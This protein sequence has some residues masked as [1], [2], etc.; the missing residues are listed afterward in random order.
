MY[1]LMPEMRRVLANA[2]YDTAAWPWLY[3]PA[4][5]R[6]ISSAGVIDKILYGS[7]FPILS[8]GRYERILSTSSLSDEDR[9]KVL[10]DNA[11]RFAS[12]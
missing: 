1:E 2:W 9:G 10:C 3:E 7:D 6:A 12:D 4:L 5:M 8:Y 11:K